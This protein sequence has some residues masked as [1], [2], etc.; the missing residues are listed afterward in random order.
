VGAIERQMG[1]F[2]NERQANLES[3]IQMIED[4]LIELGYFL[5]DCRVEIPGSYRAWLLKKGSAEVAVTLTER[6]DYWH[7][8][9]A[10]VVLS[11]TPEVNRTALYERVL[12]LNH[13]GV[14]GAAFAVRGSHITLVAERTTL[15][16]DRSEVFELIQRVR[17][18]A[19]EW[20]DRLV[21]EFGG[22]RGLAPEQLPKGK[23]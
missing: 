12:R 23:L 18:Y 6:S 17:E 13:S 21:Q 7:I 15:D 5:N 19:D 16:L 20:D 9:L 2:E 11:I 4:V 10:A 8:R 3:A 22:I 1:L 14:Y